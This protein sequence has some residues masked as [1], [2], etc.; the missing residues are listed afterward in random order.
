MKERLQKIIATAGITS[1]RHAEDLITQGRVSVNNVVITRL[2]EKADA[3]KD[4]IRIDGKTISVGKTKYYIALNKPAGFV[5]TLHDPQN[6]P[7]VVDLLSDVP[8]RVYPVGRLDYD[9]RGLLLLTNDGDFAQKVQHPRFQQPKVYRVK[10]Q[11][12]LSK[13]DLMRLGKGIKLPDSIFKPENLKIEKVNDRSCWLHLTLREGKNRIIRRGFD[14]AGYRVAMLVRE[15]IGSLKLGN[16]REGSWRQ[17]TK[18]EVDQ[19][20][21][22]VSN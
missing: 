11:G 7:T 20:L 13:E 17:L 3:G 6:R 10:I 4:V 18:K 8:E 5:T 9:S 19:L 16:L 15:S 14:A 2:G 22:N 21:N 12:H 1:R